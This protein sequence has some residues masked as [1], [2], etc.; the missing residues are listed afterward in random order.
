M[1]LAEMRARLAALKT[2]VRTFLTGNKVED[3]ESKM[4]EVRELEK[5]IKIMEEIE[6]EQRSNFPTP[7]TTPKT[8][9]MTQEQRDAAQVRAYFKSATGKSLSSEERALIVAGTSGENLILPVSVSTLINRLI[10]SYKSMRDVIG[11][12]PATTLTGS[13]PVENFDTVTGLVDFTEN[14][15]NELTE[16]TDIKFRNVS[17]ALKEKGAFVGLS[18]TLLSMNDNDLINY[19]AEV[20]AKKA[21]IT[22]NAMAFA[23]LKVGKT[24]KSL[25]D[26]KALK[27]AINVDINEALKFGATV[28]T[29]QDGFD[30]LDSAVDT[31]GKP[32]LS[33]DVAN[34]TKKLFNG[35]PITVFDNSLLPSTGTGA[36][37][38]APLFYGNLKEAARFVDNGKFSFATSEHAAF[39]KNMTLAKVIE[40]IDC[41]QVDASDKCYRYAEL[42]APQ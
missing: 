18:N 27:K 40:Y 30:A 34:P 3:A 26:W 35:C 33:M 41:I 15:T 22:E 14:G 11:Y 17:F 19:V 29:N 42:A 10:R 12:M 23:I 7:S 2:E 8:D 4:V 16:A 36:A 31:T 37:T 13:F 1:T 20:F 24:L 39:L 38:K 21:I 25:A 28:V 6:E 32:I 9:D 5:S